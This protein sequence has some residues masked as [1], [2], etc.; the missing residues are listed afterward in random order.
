MTRTDE[1]AK[2]VSNR[3][4]DEFKVEAREVRKNNGLI[5]KGITIQPVESNIGPTIY[6]DEMIDEMTDAEIADKVVEI[7][8]SQLDSME[9]LNGIADKITNRDFVLSHLTARLVNADKNESLLEEVPHTMFE[10]MAVI[11]QVAPTPE[12]STLLTYKLAEDADVEGE[13]LL[14]IALS[15]MKFKSCT[16]GQ[17]LEEMIGMPAEQFDGEIAMHV[18]TTE[19]RVFGAV[20]MLDYKLLGEVADKIGSD[21]YILPS[22]IHELIAVSSE[23]GDLGQIQDVVKSVNRTEV[24]DDEYLS[25]SVYMYSREA[26][27]VTRVA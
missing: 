22:S 6:V 1:I 26:K 10:D 15:N 9:G 21:I 4:G 23:A 19:R 11:Y 8:E 5:R 12:T 16:I 20:G 17:I 27:R 7:Y 2:M 18:I 25:D 3:M 24:S 13:D 14:K